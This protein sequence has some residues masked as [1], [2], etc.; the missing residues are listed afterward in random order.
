MTP[1]VRALRH[2]SGSLLLVA[3]TRLAVLRALDGHGPMPSLETFADD[4]A[5][6][7]LALF[8]AYL[9]AGEHPTS[10]NTREWLFDFGAVLAA[11]AESGRHAEEAAGLCDVWAGYLDATAGSTPEEAPDAA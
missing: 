11:G 4:H 3:D 5:A 7:C 9:M 10:A 1:A 8:E 2:A 6:A